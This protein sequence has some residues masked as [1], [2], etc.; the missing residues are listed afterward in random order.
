MRLWLANIIAPQGY[1]VAPYD[2][3]SQMKRAAAKSMSPA[4]RE[5]KP[6]VSNAEKHKIRY[7]AVLDAAPATIT[8]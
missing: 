1:V 5:G 6:W 7:Q 3:N 2:P 8:E 4:E